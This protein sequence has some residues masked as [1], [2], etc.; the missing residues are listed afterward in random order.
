MSRS[1]RIKKGMRL[2][3]FRAFLIRVTLGLSAAPAGHGN[4][5]PVRKDIMQSRIAIVLNLANPART[6]A[7]P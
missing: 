7:V 2:L 3:S 6:A 5:K 4:A 1:P